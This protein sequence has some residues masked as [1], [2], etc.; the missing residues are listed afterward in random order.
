M[1]VALLADQAAL[2]QLLV[3]AGEVGQRDLDVVAVVF[4]QLLAGRA[5]RSP[6][7]RPSNWPRRRRRARPSRRRRC[8]P[9]S[10]DR[11]ARSPTGRSAAG[12][13][14]STY[15]MPTRIG[16]NRAGSGACTRMRLPHGQVVST[17]SPASR[18][19][20]LVPSRYFFAPCRRF[21]S[22][23]QIGQ[24]QRRGA[25]HHLRRLA[26]R[27]VE[28]AAPDI[29]PH[30]LEARHQVRVARQAE[31]HQVEGR[32]LG[33]VRHGHVDVAELDDIAEVLRGAVELRHRH[34][35]VVHDWGSPLCRNLLR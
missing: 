23:S 19:L 22:A 2:Q 13:S 14:N 6:C 20:N 28:L 24:H 15:G 33:L 12:T 26:R 16:P 5:D 35:C 21:S 3:R 25:A 27:Q 11:T 32:R 29:H 1:L 31:A 7:C 30:V 9:G 34:H 8:R 18:K 4:G 10:R 17:T